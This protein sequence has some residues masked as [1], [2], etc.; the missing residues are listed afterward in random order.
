MT[1]GSRQSPSGG[2]GTVPLHV[3]ELYEAA[4]H[5][6]VSNQER[7]AM[8]KL[9]HEYNDMFS[10]GDHDIGL[11]RAVRHEIPLAAGTVPIQQPTR[12]LGQEK[13]KEVSQQIHD[14]LVRGLIEPAHSA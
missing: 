13:E 8:A 5:G 10:K 1:E 9:L 2:Q 11:T 7:R 4:C 14:L 12:R 3:K 6:C